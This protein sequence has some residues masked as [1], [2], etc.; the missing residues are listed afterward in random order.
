MR[1]YQ[2]GVLLLL[3]ASRDKATGATPKV[4]A[5]MDHKKGWDVHGCLYLFKDKGRREMIF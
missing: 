2:E 1:T 4:T 3:D 5:G